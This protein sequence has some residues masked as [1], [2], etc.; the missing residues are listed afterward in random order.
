MTTKLLKQIELQA[1]MMPLH[2]SAAAKI[3]AKIPGWSSAYHYLFFKSVF[4][5]FPEIRNVLIIGVYQGRDIAFMSAT[6]EHELAIVGVDKFSD[7]PC[8]DWPEEA[9]GKTWQEAGFG[10]APSVA[11]AQNNLAPLLPAKH[12]L[13]LIEADDAVWL[14]SVVG[15][16]DMIFLDTSH[17]KQT[18]I[19]Q[20][21]QVRALCHE[22]TLIAGDDYENIYPTWGV[23]D[24]VTEAFKEYQ[25]LA[26]TIWF[27]SV[28]DYK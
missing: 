9:K 19:R 21:A 26:D 22:K 12:L 15:K 11:L 10:Q 7:S 5:A 20:L 13:R 27:A 3:A 8:E 23:K 18:V 16:F 2:Q 4:T 28:E 17:D 14:P 1:A 24:A 25:V 6:C